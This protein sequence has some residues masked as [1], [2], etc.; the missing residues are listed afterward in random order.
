MK[1]KKIKLETVKIKLRRNYMII[2]QKLRRNKII[3]D[4]FT[5]ISNNC[6]AGFIYQSYN[7]PYN[8]P[9]IGMFIVAEDYIRFISNLDYYLSVKKWKKVEPR[10][11]KWYEQLCN[12]S[13]YGQYPI[14]RIDD[15]ELHLLHYSSID[16]AKKAWDR[17]KKRINKKYVLYKFSEMNLCTEKDIINFQNLKY[18]NKIC[19]ISSQFKELANE[20]TYIVSKKNKPQLAASEEPFGNSLKVNI[21]KILNNLEVE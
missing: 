13:K 9:T 6:W 5:I 14:A 18:K 2:T 12:I 3:N 15:I 21:N 1:I 7:L 17:R 19:F 10:D 8:T 20:Y 4:N 11:S 16:E